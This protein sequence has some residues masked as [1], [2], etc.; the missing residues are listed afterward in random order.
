MTKVEVI[1]FD[2]GSHKECHVFDSA[3][4]AM[5]FFNALMV[6]YHVYDGD[7]EYNE[8]E[9]EAIAQ[10]RV[11]SLTIKLSCYDCNNE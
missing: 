4:D 7:F 5:R 11:Y 2:T 8:E 3:V 9:Q 1:K 6:K 10:S